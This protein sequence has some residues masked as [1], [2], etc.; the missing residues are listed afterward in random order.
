MFEKWWQSALLSLRFQFVAGAGSIQSTTASSSGHLWC[1]SVSSPWWT[2]QCSAIAYT[3]SDLYRNIWTQ[4]YSN[5]MKDVYLRFERLRNSARETG[6]ARMVSWVNFLYW[7]SS[8]TITANDSKILKIGD[9]V[10]FRLNM[11]AFEVFWCVEIL[12]MTTVQIFFL[13]FDESWVTLSGQS[14]NHHF[15][16]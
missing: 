13:K 9:P 14:K 4:N 10:S 11:T 2:S 5:L 1:R 7:K 6:C 3:V 15:K 12:R 16:L 8:Y